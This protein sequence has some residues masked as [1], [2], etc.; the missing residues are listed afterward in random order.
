MS[1][2]HKIAVAV[3]ILTPLAAT[4][5][6]EAPE[7]P[8]LV[9]RVSPKCQISVRNR[10]DFGGACWFLACDSKKARKLGCELAA[11]SVVGAVSA[12]PDRRWLAVVSA[13]EG[14]PFLEIVDLRRLAGGRGYRAALTI[15]PYPGT[16]NPVR[17]TNDALL[18]ESDMPLPEMPIPVED[19]VSRMTD[20]PRTFR[21]QVGTWKVSPANED[22]P[23]E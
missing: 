11:M 23:K 19:A 1:C 8:P 17:W 21:I 13:G 15:N 4:A 9:E 22:S 12:S 18:V 2:R 5:S 7:S 14:H 16:I 6:D 10:S 20:P 3:L